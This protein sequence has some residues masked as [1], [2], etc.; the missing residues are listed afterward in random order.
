MPAVLRALLQGQSAWQGI[1]ASSIY[2]L[3]TFPEVWKK[4]EDMPCP[5]SSFEAWRRLAVESPGPW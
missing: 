2:W 3:R 1:V 5:F 4:L